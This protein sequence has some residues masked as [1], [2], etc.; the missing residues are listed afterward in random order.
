MTYVERIRIQWE[1]WS[2]VRAQPVSQ[3]RLS[4]SSS[5]L[6]SVQ[7]DGKLLSPLKC[8]MRFLRISLSELMWISNVSFTDFL[9]E[10]LKSRGKKAA[11]SKAGRN[12]AKIN[13]FDISDDESK[14]G[15]TKRVS[16]LKTQRVSF[17]SEDTTA[18]DLHEN[19]PDPC[20]GQSTDNNSLNALYSLNAS[21]DNGDGEFIDA[22]TAGE[23]QRKSFSFP[24]SEDA[25]LDES[26][27][28]ANSVVEPSYPEEKVSFAVE[29]GS[30]TPQ[31][32]A[33]DRN[34]RSS[35]GLFLL[36]NTQIT[37]SMSRIIYQLS[38]FRQW[39]C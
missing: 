2:C 25:P 16:F 22:R 18:S 11:A 32:P 31:L 35:A 30:L 3:P 10:L 12:K 23:K 17:P 29:Q 13:D 28:S 20:G 4:Y 27:A 19:E 26:L 9:N 14:R 36:S 1:E 39:C 5:I 34:H 21:E 33:L 15:R 6:S 7:P 38:L 8:L 24:S 37:K